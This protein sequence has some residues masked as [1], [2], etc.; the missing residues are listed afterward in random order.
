[1]QVREHQSAPERLL[2]KA[3][4][5]QTFDVLC[6]AAEQLSPSELLD[7]EDDL[8]LYE[9]TRLIGIHMSRLMKLL[10]RQ[11]A[12]TLRHVT[13]ATTQAAHMAN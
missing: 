11:R 4:T 6:K 7:L 10:K 3:G 13:K 8:R 12:L 9:E 5:E 1:M 2:C